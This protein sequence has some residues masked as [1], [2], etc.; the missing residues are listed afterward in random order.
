MLRSTSV[1]ERSLWLNSAKDFIHI[2]V[3]K[4]TIFQ[5][6][7]VL[8]AYFRQIHTAA[9]GKTLVSLLLLTLV[10]VAILGSYPSWF[11]SFE[12]LQTEI[13]EPWVPWFKTIYPLK[14]YGRRK[15]WTNGRADDL[16]DRKLNAYACVTINSGTHVWSYE[17]PRL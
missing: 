14:C 8:H 7:H 15:L 4:Y 13:W 2:D 10:A 12:A 17:A 5:L 1:V 16:T 3:S 6:I 11:L 9:L